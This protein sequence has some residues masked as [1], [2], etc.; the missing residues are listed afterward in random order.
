MFKLAEHA[1][2]PWPVKLRRPSQTKAGE[3]ET[4][5]IEVRFL[6]LDDEQLEAIARESM[7]RNET[8]AQ[9]VARFVRGWRNVPDVHGQ[10][11]PFTKENL[12]ALLK[13]PGVTQRFI[14]EY[15]DS[16]LRA[17]EKN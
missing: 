16:R 3:F 8:N 5:E 11:V 17:A 1:E 12:A 4:V 2:Y 14:D 9:Y 7:E 13:L 15:R 10:E 6:Y